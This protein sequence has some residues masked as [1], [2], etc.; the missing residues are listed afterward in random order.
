MLHELLTKTH[1]NVVIVGDRKAIEE[2][3]K[4]LNLGPLTVVETAD[5]VK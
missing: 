2:G 5:V 3:V 1:P 4:A